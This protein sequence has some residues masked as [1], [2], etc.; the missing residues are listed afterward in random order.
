MPRF[1]P[2]FPIG[3]VLA[4]C[5]SLPPVTHPLYWA[6][7]ADGTQ[8]VGTASME[9]NAKSVVLKIPASATATCSGLVGEYVRH[10]GDIDVRLR[11]APASAPCDQANRPAFITHIGPLP[12][13]SYDVS[14]T[15]DDKPL[16]E[17]N[18]VRID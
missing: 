16:I 15:L 2:S 9:V 18:R 10:G 4:A 13:G 5:V 11:Q 6:R 7:E 17:G 14:V 1:R 8:A 3:V 12:D